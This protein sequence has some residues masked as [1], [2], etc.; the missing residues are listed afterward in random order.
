MT[1]P[2]KLSNLIGWD[3][4]LQEIALFSQFKNS[5]YYT[6]LLRN[7]GI[8]DNTSFVNIGANTSY[9]VPVLPSIYK[10]SPANGIP[11]LQSIKYGSATALSTDQV[12]SEI[13]ATIERMR[14]A[15]TITGP[16]TTP[17]FAI[18]SSHTPFELTVSP[19]AIQKGFCTQLYGLQGVRNTFY[20]GAAFHRHDSSL[21]WQFTKALLPSVV[22][23]LT[24]S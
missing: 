12:K 1:I 19:D 24:A 10:I 16:A 7:T 3:L 14:E 21:L 23:N 2:P 8:P 13:L 9:N 15:G 22:G 17:E 18:F 20:T 11:G 6:C 5:A 4:S